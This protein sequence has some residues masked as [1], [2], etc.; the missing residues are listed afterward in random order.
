MSHRKWEGHVT[1]TA[2]CDQNNYPL[3]YVFAIR[4]FMFTHFIKDLM[5]FKFP[6]AMCFFTQNPI[7]NAYEGN[8]SLQSDLLPFIF[9][10]T[11]KRVFR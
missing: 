5:F 3:I 1:A 8:L 6:Y 9:K 7:V 4:R 10:M 2:S 11:R